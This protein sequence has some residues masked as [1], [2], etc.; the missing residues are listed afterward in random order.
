[1]P[2][3][4][5]SIDDFSY[6]CEVNVVKVSQSIIIKRKKKELGFVYVYGKYISNHKHMNWDLFR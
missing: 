6:K 3:E 2:K 1:M 4:N 5:H